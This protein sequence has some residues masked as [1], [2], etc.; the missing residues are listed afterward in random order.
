MRINTEV[1]KDQIFDTLKGIKQ[2]LS[3]IKAD[4]QE[5]FSK[6]DS[7]NSHLVA[8]QDFSKRRA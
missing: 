7:I 2:D 5:I 1:T 8:K 6:I 3:I 4:I